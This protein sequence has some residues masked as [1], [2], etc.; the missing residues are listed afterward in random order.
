MA[1]AKMSQ[2]TESAKVK[3][4]AGTRAFPCLKF[5][6]TESSWGTH[7]VCAKHMLE[8]PIHLRQ[9]MGKA[10]RDSERWQW[11]GLAP[12]VLMFLRPANP[13]SP[14]SPSSEKGGARGGKT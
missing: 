1:K 14:A 5:G 3:V 9:K 4:T 8:I 10:I 11:W 2:K 6:C 12:E 7:P 13:S